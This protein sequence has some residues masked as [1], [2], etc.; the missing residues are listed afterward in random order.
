MLYGIQKLSLQ[1]L[2][3]APH[4]D[5]EWV[6]YCKGKVVKVTDKYAGIIETSL[7][8]ACAVNPNWCTEVK[9]NYKYIIRLNLNNTS[10]YGN[11]SNDN[12]SINYDD[13]QNTSNFQFKIDIFGH[14]S[15]KEKAVLAEVAEDYYLQQM[16]HMDIPVL[17]MNY[18]LMILIY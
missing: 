11:D 4:K 10:T 8:A 1:V 15:E 3:K 7:G 18:S 5:E 9:K 6:E 13:I 2:C 16:I 17:Y 12:S 14:Y